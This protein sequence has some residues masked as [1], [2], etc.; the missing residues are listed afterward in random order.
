[1]AAPTPDL[2]VGEEER[3]VS[4]LDWLYAGRSVPLYHAAADIDERLVGGQV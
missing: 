4:P 2:P 1:L 3:P